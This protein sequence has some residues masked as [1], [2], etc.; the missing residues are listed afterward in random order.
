MVK[1]GDKF[2]IKGLELTVNTITSDSV[3]LTY[4]SS[5]IQ[6][7]AMVKMSGLLKVLSTYR[8]LDMAA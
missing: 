5:G 3:V 8:I 4:S 2:R 7:F 1:Q 6:R